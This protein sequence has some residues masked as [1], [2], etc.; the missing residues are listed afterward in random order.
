MGLTAGQATSK[1]VAFSLSSLP[2][3]VRDA[4]IIC[5]HLEIKFLW[6]DALCIIQ[7]SPNA[8]DWTRESA[9]MDQIYGNAFFTLAA[10]GAPDI[11]REF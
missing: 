3:T 7:D 2:A 1:L 9:A 6:V 8:E 10:A 11:G 5:R 4:V